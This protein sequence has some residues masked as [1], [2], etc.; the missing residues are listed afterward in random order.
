MFILPKVK[1]ALTGLVSM[2]RIKRVIAGVVVA[3]GIMAGA[4]LPTV[5]NAS[6]APLQPTS[7]AVKIG[8]L[9]LTQSSSTH[10]QL[11]DHESHASHESHS[12]HVSHYSS[13]D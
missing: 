4:A 5:A 11:A 12:S 3:T 8:A 7:P 10:T 1:K 6:T 9:L 2:K 13:R